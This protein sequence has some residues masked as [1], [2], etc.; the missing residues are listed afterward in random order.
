[1]RRAK[2]AI[3]ISDVGAELGG[4]QEKRKQ[5][6]LPSPD[7]EAISLTNDFFQHE[8]SKERSAERKTGAQVSGIL[9]MPVLQ[10]EYGLGT[11]IEPNLLR[12]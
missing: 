12:V 8:P 10:G 6:G 11:I 5:P 9:G 4:E 2:N 3:R 1:L 7:H